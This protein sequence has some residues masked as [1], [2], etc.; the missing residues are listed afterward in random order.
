MG[1]LQDNLATFR[2]KKPSSVQAWV[3]SVL[4]SRS[5]PVPCRHARGLGVFGCPAPG[6]VPPGRMSAGGREIVDISGR[7]KRSKWFGKRSSCST[8]CAEVSLRA[9]S[10][11]AP[12]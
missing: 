6:P 1:L 3:G 8:G 4:R 12:S 5:R 9:L 7:A 11:T 2:C 10:E